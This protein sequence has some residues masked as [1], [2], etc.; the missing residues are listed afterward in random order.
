MFPS[1]G[2]SLFLLRLGK[3][4]HTKRHESHYSI[5][6]TLV[7]RVTYNRLIHPASASRVDDLSNNVHVVFATG[8]EIQGVCFAAVCG[9]TLSS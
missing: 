5:K 9:R 3:A 8:V 4:S 1:R 6:E 7:M 2:P